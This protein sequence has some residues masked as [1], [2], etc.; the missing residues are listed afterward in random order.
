M[1]YSLFLF[2]TRLIFH[3]LMKRKRKKRGILKTSSIID[4]ALQR[5]PNQTKQKS[6]IV[7]F[8]FIINIINNKI[9]LFFLFLFQKNLLL[10]LCNTNSK[11][12][13]NEFS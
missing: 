1:F 2:T 13:I 12:I 4:V 11:I 10:I 6:F 7:F 9:F 5:K 8:L 3:I